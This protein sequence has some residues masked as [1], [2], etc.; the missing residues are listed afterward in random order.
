MIAFISYSNKDEE[1][2]MRFREVLVVNGVDVW[3]D[4]LSILPGQRWQETIEAAIRSCSH[5][6]VLLSE[7]SID[8]SEVE[9]EWGL[10]L[11]L[12]KT[13][14]PILLDDVALPYRLRSVQSLNLRALG[15]EKVLSQLLRVLPKEVLSKHLLAPAKGSQIP[16]KYAMFRRP[17][18]LGVLM[19]PHSYSCIGDLLDDLFIHYLADIVPPYSYGSEWILS[20]EPFRCLLLVPWEWVQSPGRSVI[21]IAPSWYTTSVT[22]LTLRP[23]TSWE[24]WTK[25]DTTY[26]FQNTCDARYAVAS[27]NEMVARL[28]LADAKAVSEI[29]RT[30]VLIN[31]PFGEIDPHDY[32][33]RYVF[34]DWL[35]IGLSGNVI[36]DSGKEMDKRLETIFA[37]KLE[38]D[39]K[40]PVHYFWS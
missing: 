3:I 28:L 23:K 31:R 15:I 30:G 26:F 34:R 8:S 6:V 19:R 4:Q 27:N 32:K 25:E 9:A 40:D 39:L 2:A 35:Q 22:Q 33:Y 5:I 1:I 17:A 20:G 14:V 10:G 37:R 16:D 13:V 18:G 24:I 11:S 7:N 36:T 21:E 38:E 29:Y 12:G